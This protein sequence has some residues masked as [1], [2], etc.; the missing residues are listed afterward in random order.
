MTIAP[1]KRKILRDEVISKIR[2]HITQNSLKVGDRLPTEQEMADQ[3]GVSRVSIREATKALS[4]FGVIDSAPRRG[5]T[6]GAVNME[7][8]AD[9]LGFHFTLDDYPKELLLKARLVIEIG[10]LQYTCEAM[11]S[12]P[13]LYEKLVEMCVMMERISDNEMFIQSDANFHCTLVESSGV[14]P[15]VAFNH[16]LQ[17]FFMRFRESLL[18]YQNHWSDGVHSHR[19]IVECLHDGKLTEAE[20][21]L[22]NHLEIYKGAL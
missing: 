15:L 18:E 20:K 7:R 22:R 21:M 10:S 14:E 5:L 9:V 8:V 3:L 17:A 6:V 1:V 11:S 4:F 19:D 13:S 12:D 16:V 2:E